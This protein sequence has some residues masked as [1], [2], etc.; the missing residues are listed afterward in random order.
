[1]FTTF[2]FGCFICYILRADF[3]IIKEVDRMEDN[4]PTLICVTTS[5]EVVTACHT[6]CGPFWSDD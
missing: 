5:E 6:D 3:Y 4:T 1:M 2:R